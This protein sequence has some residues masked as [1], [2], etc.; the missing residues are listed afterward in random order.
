MNIQMPDKNVNKSME[1]RYAV[2]HL[3]TFDF[4]RTQTFQGGSKIDNFQ[5]NNNF[6]TFK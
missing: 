4:S 2:G 1:K 6:A 5:P 3:Y